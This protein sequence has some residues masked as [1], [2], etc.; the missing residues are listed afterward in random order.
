VTAHAHSQHTRSKQHTPRDARG[1]PLT[2]PPPQ[3]P[4]AHVGGGA[5]KD[6]FPAQGYTM[7]LVQKP[8]TLLFALCAVAVCIS[9]TAAVVCQGKRERCMQTFDRPLLAVLCLGCLVI[10][11]GLVFAEMSAGRGGGGGGMRR[12]SPTPSPMS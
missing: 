2:T 3:S 7:R 10:S 8:V 4:S 1:E 11:F 5:T 6:I 12:V 9:L